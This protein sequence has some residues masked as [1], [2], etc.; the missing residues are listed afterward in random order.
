MVVGLV[1]MVVCDVLEHT[2]ARRLGLIEVSGLLLLGDQNWKPRIV[3]LP[4]AQ[5]IV[6][7]QAHTFPLA[8]HSNTA[9]QHPHL[10]YCSRYCVARADGGHW[11][12]SVLSCAALSASTVRIA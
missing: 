12:D 4:Q 2:A 11:M 10:P 9:E 3:H 5:R 7:L 8:V 1:V 6:V